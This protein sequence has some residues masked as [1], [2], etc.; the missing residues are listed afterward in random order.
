MTIA[1]KRCKDAEKMAG[2]EW[3]EDERGNKMGRVGG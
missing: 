1:A 2:D 3:D